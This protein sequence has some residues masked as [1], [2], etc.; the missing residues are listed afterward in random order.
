MARAGAHVQ[1]ED[2]ADPGK[3]LTEEKSTLNREIQDLK[4]MLEV[5]ERKVNELQN[6]MENLQEQLGTRRSRWVA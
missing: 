1:R 2:Q 5:K 4:D 3:D 6:R